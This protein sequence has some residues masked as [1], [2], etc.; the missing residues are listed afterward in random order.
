ML[1]MKESNM[2]H[3]PHPGLRLFPIA[4]TVL[5]LSITSPLL[6][7]GETV[8]LT[9]LVRDFLPSHPDFDV[10]GPGGNGHNMWNVDPTLGPDGKPVYT[11]GGF[12]VAAQYEDASGFPICW[13]LYDPAL[14]DTEGAAAS[15]DDANIT[16][17]ATF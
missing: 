3:R 8:A 10:S 7:A 6:A 4:C 12:K 14:G 15:S 17:A 13:T 2:S 11:G 9:G 16:S 5:A 1:E